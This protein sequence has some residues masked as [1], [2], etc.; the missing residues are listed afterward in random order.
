MASAFYRV[1]YTLRSKLERISFLRKQMDVGGYVTCPQ[2]LHS[3]MELYIIPKTKIKSKVW[4]LV[5]TSL[6]KAAKVRRS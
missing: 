4:E 5:K 2:Q 1:L 6:I 3:F